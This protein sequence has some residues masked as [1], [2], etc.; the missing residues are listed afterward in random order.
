[1]L[2]PPALPARPCHRQM[3]RFLAPSSRR[4]GPLSLSSL[5]CTGAS[6]GTACARSKRTPE[7]PTVTKI[8]HAINIVHEVNKTNYV[9]SLGVDAVHMMRGPLFSDEHSTQVL[10]N[11]DAV[12]DG[13]L[14]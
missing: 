12:I 9:R 2:S 3:C 14:R 4:N 13:P 8:D 1:M 5:Y 10:L 7:E 6:P 11:C